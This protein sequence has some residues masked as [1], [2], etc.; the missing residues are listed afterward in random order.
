MDIF[1]FW[2]AHHQRGEEQEDEYEDRPQGQ[3]SDIIEDPRRELGRKLAA[4]GSVRVE[5][6]HM[7]H[8]PTLWT[9]IVPDYERHTARTK[10]V[11]VWRND[12][13]VTVS[14]M[15]HYERHYEYTLQTSRWSDSKVTGPRR[16][17]SQ[18]K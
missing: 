6:L 1:N 9:R 12:E 2:R 10:M 13:Y 4:L 17:L 5:L 18:W 15:N 7:L 3:L 11:R 14:L 8:L 16:R